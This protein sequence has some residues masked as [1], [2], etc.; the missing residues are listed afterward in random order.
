MGRKKPKVS[1]IFPSYNHAPFIAEAIESG[2]VQTYSDFEMIISDDAST[3]NSAEILSRYQDPRIKLHIFEKNQ[4]AT[5][6]GRYMLDCVKGEYVAL[7]NSDDV[8]TK[9]RLQKG[10]DY[11]DKHPE[12]GAVFSWAG[13]IDED[14][15]VIDP[16]CEIF[17]QP[18]R[19][20]AE[21]IRRLFTGGNCLCH[22][23]M[24]IRS[25]AYEIAGRY[26]LGMR[27]LPDFYMWVC[28]LKHYTIHIIPEVLT[29]HR[30][31]IHTGQNTSSPLLNNSI[32]DV[33]ESLFVLMHFFEG[34]SDE[35]FIEAFSPLFRNPKATSH[36]ELLCEK[37][38]L[39]L[40][41]KYYMKVIP[42]LAGFLYFLNIYDL[43]NVLEIFRDVYGYT[44]QDFH[45][46][47]S[48]IDLLGLK[49][50]RS[51]E[52][53]IEAQEQPQQYY[54]PNTAK[55]RIKALLWGIFGKDTKAYEFF[56]RIYFKLRGKK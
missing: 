31:F 40:D 34:I 1:I 2:L 21:W 13:L 30:R 37:F 9:D 43:P 45:E 29:W 39:M 32:R 35:L 8:W 44:M 52:V 17:R 56:Y 54:N 27:Q 53:I 26:K 6:N 36:E 55:E 4:G 25:K 51:N 24:L 46:L 22:P 10:V 11:L 33:N 3:D 14:S 48:R 16:C 15:N 7:L 12:C 18:N 20:Q 41:E 50:L 42:L 38:F 23:S 5:L 49:T 19:T 28:L 47:G